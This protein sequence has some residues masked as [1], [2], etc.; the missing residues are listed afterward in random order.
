MPQ[1]GEVANRILTVGSTARAEALSK[2]LQPLNLDAPLLQMLSNRGF[3]TSTGEPY[4]PAA[5]SARM[6][7]P[8]TPSPSLD[9]LPSFCVHVRPGLYE[10]VPVSI[11]S[12]L[13]GTPNMDFMVRECRA[14]VQGQ[15]AIVRLGT[16]GALQPPAKLGDLLIASA[17]LLVRRNPDAWTADGQ[18]AY[19]VSLPVACD[20]DLAA[21]LTAEGRSLLGEGN[22]QQGLNATADSFYSSQVR[23][24]EVGWAGGSTGRWKW[25]K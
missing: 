12:H 6:H 18:D 13:M 2:L 23:E 5:A 1:P 11:V 21:T 15:M 25:L 19:T 7:H 8:G 24:R 22:V 17:G 14:V 3:H 10:G 20:A 9:P 16:C 4:A